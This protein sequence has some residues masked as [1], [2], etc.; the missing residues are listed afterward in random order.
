M[1]LGQGKGPFAPTRAIAVLIDPRNQQRQKI[2]AGL[3][4]TPTFAPTMNGVC[5]IN[6]LQDVQL[7]ELKHTRHIGGVLQKAT[8]GFHAVLANV[9]A[10][11]F[12]F[13]VHPQAH[14][15]L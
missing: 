5:R 8:V 10:L 15:G 4:P 12:L 2:G 1:N 14:G 13:G 9:E 11:H 3:P 7:T 6:R